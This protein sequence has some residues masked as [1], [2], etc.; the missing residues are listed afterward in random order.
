MAGSFAAFEEEFL[1][2]TSEIIWTT[3]TTVDGKGRPRSRILHPIWQVIDGLPVGWI[4]TGKTPVKA[5]HL[6][7]NP[8]VACSYWSPAQNTVTIDC[9]AS[10][11]EGAAS[12]RHVWDLFMSTPPPLGYDLT[13]FG[14]AGVDDPR[15]TPL[16]LDPWRIQ[17]LRF[18][19]W[20]GN[21][22]PRLWQAEGRG[23]TRRHAN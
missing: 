12:K 20:G 5:G 22:T 18:E 17:I 23:E 19:G 7:H 8:H 10:W 3:V 4:V 2:F 11:V 15:F 1:R 9:V 14:S 13:A 21:L 6:A 16:R